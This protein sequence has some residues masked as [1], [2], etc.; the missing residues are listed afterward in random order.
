MNRDLFLA[1]LAMDSYNRGYGRGVSLK[2]GLARDIIVKEVNQ[3]LGNVLIKKQD[4][5]LDAI[6]AGFYAIAYDVS[7]A[8]VPGLSGMVISYRGTTYES[9]GSFLSS[10][11]DIATGWPVGAGLLARQSTLALEFYKDINNGV[12]GFDLT[13]S[14][15]ITLTGHSLGGGLSGFV[16]AIT[17]TNS[18]LFDPMPFAAANDDAGWSLAA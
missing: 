14:Q 6:N 11:R 9:N 16:G 7:E 17:G 10:Y 12:S 8:G 2:H 5:S 3:K 18:I 15:P 1:I 4:V 13:P